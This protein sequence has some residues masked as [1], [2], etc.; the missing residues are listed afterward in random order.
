MASIFRFCRT[1]AKR[2]F[3]HLPVS[4]WRCENVRFWSKSSISCRTRTKVLPNLIE[5]DVIKSLES[6]PI[7][8]EVRRNTKFQPSLTIFSNW[9]GSQ[10]SCR[11][12]GSFYT[13]QLVRVF[14]LCR[15]DALSCRQGFRSRTFEYIPLVASMGMKYWFIPKICVHTENGINHLIYK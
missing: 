7:H 4:L 9:V 14:G 8:A 5:F 10:N 13:R 15:I 2:D 12:D 1:K 11:I 6:S 3:L